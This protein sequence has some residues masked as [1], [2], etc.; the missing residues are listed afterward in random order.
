MMRLSDRLYVQV[1]AEFDQTGFVKP[2][3]ITWQD[4]RNFKI[5]EIQSFSDASAIQPGLSG[6]CYTV[7]IRNKTKQLFLDSKSLGS[8]RL[9]FRWYV[10]V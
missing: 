3:S 7:T 9:F 4:G 10:L 6:I 1:E 2:K 5:D 8:S